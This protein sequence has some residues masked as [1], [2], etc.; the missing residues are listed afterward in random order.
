MKFGNDFPYGI[1]FLGV[2]VMSGFFLFEKFSNQAELD[3]KQNLDRWVENELARRLAE[4]V[5]ASPEEVLRVFS[6]DNETELSRKVRALL[7]T[8]EVIFVQ[9]SP[10]TVRR[11]IETQL[12]DGT[13]LSVTSDTLWDDLP[14]DIRSEFLKTGKKRISVPWKYALDSVT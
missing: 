5:K 8:V 7:G 13:S 9:S 2:L 1:V 14:A 3:S 4:K 10:S 11:S 6:T 12:M